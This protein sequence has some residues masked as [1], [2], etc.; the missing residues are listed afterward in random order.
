MLFILGIIEIKPTLKL[1]YLCKY[2]YTTPKYMYTNNNII[3]LIKKLYKVQ[4]LFFL[5]SIISVS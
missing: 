2:T 5:L 3:K 4:V 1:M